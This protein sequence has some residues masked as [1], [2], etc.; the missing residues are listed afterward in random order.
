MKRERR[1]NRLG[2]SLMVGLLAFLALPSVASAQRGRDDDPEITRSPSVVG[3]PVVGQRLDADASWR[4]DGLL[5]ILY[6]WLRCDSSSL[7]S[8]KIQWSSVGRSYTLT[9]ADRGKFM[10]VWLGVSNR[11]GR[12][13]AI[14]SP[15]AAVAAAPVAPP[16]VVPPPPPVTPPVTVTPPVV[17]PPAA[18]SPAPAGGNVR[19]ARARTMR[20]FPVVRLRGWL[21]PRGARIRMFTVNAPKGSRITVRCLGERCPRSRWARSTVMTRVRGFE[22]M[23]RA[24]VRL[25]LRITRP[26][27]IGKHTIIRIRE[28]KAPARRDR[29]L[30]PGNTAPQACP[31][32]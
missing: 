32:R 2:M 6:I 19:G 30:Y 16:P 25:E 20:P 8:C 27:F 14:S 23:L 5:S 31:G 22:G 4:G 29:C 13:D 10:R 28:G 3:A 1:S 12:D 7:W 15:T 9:E 24:G 26:G 11:D 21:T 17:T 18:D